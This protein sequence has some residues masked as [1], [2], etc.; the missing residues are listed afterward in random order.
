MSPNGLP[1]FLRARD[2]HEEAMRG[3]HADTLPTS[4]LATVFAGAQP[5]DAPWV[6]RYTA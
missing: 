6:A 4:L 1:E 5:G 2:N 3:G